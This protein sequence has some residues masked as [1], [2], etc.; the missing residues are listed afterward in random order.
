MSLFAA[1]TR[2]WHYSVENPGA[3]R[4]LYREGNREYTFPLYQEKGA[5][6]LVGV[7]SAQRIHF[8]FNWYAHHQEFSAAARDRILPRIEKHLR[9]TGA[10]VRVF[11]RGRS[12]ENFEFYPELFEERGRAAEL[13]EEAGYTWFKDYCAIDLLHGEYGLEICGIQNEEDVRVIAAALRGGF[14]HWHHQSVCLHEPGREPGWT[15]ALCMFPA[16]LRSSEWPDGD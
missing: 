10:R 4:L 7:P 5:L 14:P 2:K 8:F 12:D 9:A 6:V 1:L 3:G 16:R 15:V 11:E 13:L